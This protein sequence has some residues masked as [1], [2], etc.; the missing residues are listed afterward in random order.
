LA[1]ELAISGLLHCQAKRGVQV[2][3][4]KQYDST[5]LN[6]KTHENNTKSSKSIGISKAYR[7]YYPIKERIEAIPNKKP[8]FT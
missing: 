7:I 8:S 4:D 2:K 1:I 6:R 3:G 5:V